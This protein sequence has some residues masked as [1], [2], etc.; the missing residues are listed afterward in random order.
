MRLWLWIADPTP[1]FLTGKMAMIIYIGLLSPQHWL[2]FLGKLL[3]Q[4]TPNV[5]QGWRCHIQEGCNMLIL[6]LS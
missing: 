2:F 1:R 6:E 5:A 3:S 4:L